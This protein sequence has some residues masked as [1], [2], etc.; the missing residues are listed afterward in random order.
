MPDGDFA[1]FKEFSDV[2]FEFEQSHHVGDEGSR[3]AD[4]ARDGFLL[5][6]EAGE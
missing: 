6:V 5:H 4:V 3:F 1:F 2:F